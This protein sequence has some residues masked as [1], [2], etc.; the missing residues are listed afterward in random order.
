MR[1]SIQ[2]GLLFVPF[3]LAHADEIVRLS[4]STACAR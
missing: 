2:P 1:T 3:G 4:P